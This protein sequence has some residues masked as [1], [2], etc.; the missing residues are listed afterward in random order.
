MKKPELKGMAEWKDKEMQNIQEL[1]MEDCE[2][3][4]GGES[5]LFWAAYLLGSLIRGTTGGASNSGQSV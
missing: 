1:S 4:N 2:M 3:V 5:P